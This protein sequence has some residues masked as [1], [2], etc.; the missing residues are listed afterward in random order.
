MTNIKTSSW[1]NGLGSDYLGASTALAMALS[2]NRVLLLRSPS[3]G[4]FHALGCEKVSPSCFFL[5]ESACN[6]SQIDA[7][8]SANRYSHSFLDPDAA[9]QWPEIS[10]NG[11]RVRE[12][13]NRKHLL[14]FRSQVDTLSEKVYKTIGV[15]LT[16]FRERSKYEKIRLWHTQA[17]LYLLRLNKNMQQIVRRGLLKCTSSENL[18]QA[19]V[20]E[21]MKRTLGLPL[22]GSDKCFKNA[23]GTNNPAG[24]M[25]C[26]GVNEV[27]DA[28][29]RMYSTQPWIQN[30]LVTSEDKRLSN[31][32]ARFLKKE[33]NIYTNLDDFQQ[34]TGSTSYN[35]NSSV[36]PFQVTQETLVTLACQSMPSMH[37]VTIRSNFHSLIDML[38][39]CIPGKRSHFS[40]S[41]G[42][43]YRPV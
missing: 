5:P 36:M 38:S 35:K 24:E 26:V 27:K 18:C 1:N 12:I 31:E 25:L 19:Q 10:K 23:D 28:V 9:G 3:G 41:I 16:R 34:G 39:K 33:W 14:R 11:A 20:D 22:R 32:A 37:L 13:R 30:V 15:S 29:G 21:N 7:H 17:S 4:W 42:M 40:Y 43:N 2:S 6:L 8:V